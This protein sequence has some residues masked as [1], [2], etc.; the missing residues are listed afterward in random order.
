MPHGMLDA[1]D[2]SGLSLRQVLEQEHGARTGQSAAAV[3]VVAAL[4]L[5][6]AGVRE[7]VE[8]HLEQVRSPA[9]TVLHLQCTST[10]APQRPEL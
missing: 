9:R 1:Q 6:R 8:V 4:A 2:K 10:C 7:Y 5:P 3:D